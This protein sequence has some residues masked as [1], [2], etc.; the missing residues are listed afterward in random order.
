MKARHIISGILCLC[1]VTSF[2]AVPFMPAAAAETADGAEVLGSKVYGSYL[3]KEIDGGVEITAFS[4]M[5]EADA[6]SVPD[7]IDG[8][9]VISIGEHGMAGAHAESIWLPATV[10]NIGDQAFFGCKNLTSVT[11]NGAV[12]SI[13]DE[14]FCNCTKLSDVE[15]PFTLESIGTRAFYNTALTEVRLGASLHFIG[16]SAFESCKAL[17]SVD[18]QPNAVQEL[19]PGTF[20]GCEA[21]TKL[22][23]PENV[24]YLYGRSLPITLRVLFVRSPKAEV[25]EDFGLFLPPDCTVYADPDAPAYPNLGTQVF[26]LSDYE[27][28]Q[29]DVNGDYQFD[30]LDVIALTKYLHMDGTLADR[31]AADVYADG[32]IDIFD[33]AM[34]MRALVGLPINRQ[35]YEPMPGVIDIQAKNLAELVTANPVETVDIGSDI[36]LGQTDFALSLLRETIRTGEKQGENVLISP[37]SVSQALGMTAN[38]AAGETLSEMESVLGGK[39]DTLNPAFYTLRSRLDDSGEDAKFHTANS[40]WFRDGYAI[41][42]DFLQKNA[43]YYGAAA[44]EAPFDQSTVDDINHWVSDNTDQMIPQVID[45]I[46]E[47]SKVI[48]ANAV[49]FDALWAEPYDEEYQVSDADF[50]AADGTVQTAQMMYDELHTY[51]EDEHAAGFMKSYSGGYAFAALLPEEGMTPEDYL[52]TLDAKDV[53]DMFTKMREDWK[54]VRTGLPQFSYDFDTMMNAPLAEMGMP[55]AF[56][57]IADFSGMTDAPLG[58]HIGSVIHKTHI[59][60]TAAGTRAAAATVVMMDETSAAPDPE[61]PKTVILDRPFV[62]MIVET[63]NYLPVFIGTVNSVE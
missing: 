50:T 17:N 18:F 29:F 11:I 53:Q 43:D 45:Q 60:L 3:Y 58:L 59:D 37:Y 57:N 20:W 34:M 2:G 24:Q 44:Y 63:D 51:I 52:E 31:S 21:L 15:L 40:I 26:R 6:I 23:L 32:E 16:E 10:T 1:M 39:M 46:P 7:E 42:K 55:G 38:G 62:Y 47:E 5:D 41:R 54:P 12:T 27:E 13:G 48:L 28:P 49:V 22:D 25:M 9:P 61:E 35:P 56:S 30:I 36:V 4:T 8:K 33:L 14:A 19:L